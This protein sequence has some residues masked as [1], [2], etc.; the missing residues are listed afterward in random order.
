MARARAR[1]QVLIGDT[2]SPS[3]GALLDL[4]RSLQP[5]VNVELTT[6]LLTAQA[7]ADAAAATADTPLERLRAL[8]A[9][10]GAAAT[11]DADDDDWESE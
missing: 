1:A 11:T 8:T 6:A 10:N 3:F 9:A 2:V 4:L 5:Y 7:A